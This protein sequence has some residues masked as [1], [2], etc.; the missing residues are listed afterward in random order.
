MKKLLS[1]LLA[2]ALVLS[3]AACGADQPGSTT[4][5]GTTPGNNPSEGVSGGTATSVTYWMDPQNMS[6]NTVSSFNDQEAWK[7]YEKNLG[8]DIIWQEPPSGQ[9]GEQFNLIISTTNLPDIMYYS[10]STAYPGGPDAAIADGKI[11]ALNDYIEEYAPNFYAYLEAHPDVR[12]EITTD[13][14]NI[15]CFPAVY[16]YTSESSPVWQNAIDREPYQESF[17]GLVIRQDLLDQAGLPMPETL[18]DWYNTLVKF[19]EMGIEYPFSTMA[20]FMTMAQVFNTAYDISVPI[21]GM[22]M[23]MA[24]AGSAFTLTDSG[25]IVY[26]PATDEYK[27]YLSFLHRLYDEG[28]LDHDFMVQDRTTLATKVING[29][30]GAWVEMMPTGLGNLKAQVLAI[31]P[32]SPFNP[33]GALAP[34]Q[35]KGQ[36]LT[37]KQGSPA[38]T[39]SGAAITTS[40]ED[41]ITACKV[42]DYG[43][44]EEGNRI[45]NWGIEGVSYEF[46]DGWPKLTD[47]II[48]NDQGLLPSEAFSLY[49]NLNGPYPMDHSQRLESKRD[50]SLAAGETDQNLASLDLWSSSANGLRAVGLPT[51]TML[52]EESAAYAN[53]FNEVCTYAEE[54]FAK[55]VMG[56]ESLDKY[57]DYQK[58]LNALGLQTVLDLQAGALVRYN[59]RIK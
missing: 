21:V 26:G 7:L 43:W 41:I 22:G 6:A 30:V 17:I 24:M 52:A 55:F 16:T 39:G 25:E 1:F 46:V 27:E 13:S 38:Y 48:H 9:A 11:I 47:A 37:Y 5:S 44:S 45:L 42:L 10:W 32:D 14:G 29:Q 20:A 28:L 59:E 49:R 33:V 2:C 50:Y 31:D 3:L 8:I 12:Q 19:K 23:G 35:V 56:T 15:Y 58:N 4:P 57:E 36:Q 40:C 34:V 53:S 51:T 18:D 54:M